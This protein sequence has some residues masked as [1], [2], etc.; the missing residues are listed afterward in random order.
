MVQSLLLNVS[1]M[2]TAVVHTDVRLCV[3]SRPSSHGPR[4]FT[5]GSILFMTETHSKQRQCPK[6]LLYC[7]I[8]RHDWRA[9]KSLL[10]CQASRD[11]GGSKTITCNCS[12]IAAKGNLKV[13]RLGIALPPSR[14]IAATLA[15]ARFLAI[16][17]ARN[18]CVVAV[19]CSKLRMLAT[20]PS[21]A[22]A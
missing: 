11:H 18:A 14:V 6:R 17:S 22:D 19:L 8:R 7:S 1:A 21:S 2:I 12:L 5:S 15:V 16:I 4:E 3:R 9:Y 13:R 10:L 20:F